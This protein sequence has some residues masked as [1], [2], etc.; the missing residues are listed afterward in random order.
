MDTKISLPPEL[1]NFLIQL[2]NEA[3]KMLIDAIVKL[4]KDYLEHH[5]LVDFLA[6]LGKLQTQST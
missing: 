6:S 2:A 4:I 1:I 5:N 3:I